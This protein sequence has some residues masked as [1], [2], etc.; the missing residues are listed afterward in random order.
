M[1]RR[2]RSDFPPPLEMTATPA[3]KFEAR[4]KR[5]IL[6]L[7]WLSTGKRMRVYQGDPAKLAGASPTLSDELLQLVSSRYG[8][9]SQNAVQLGGS[10]N[11]NVRLNEYVVRVY[12]PWVVAERLQ[13]MQRVRQELRAKGVPIPELKAARD[14]SYSCIFEDCL[15]EVEQFIDGTPMATWQQ[16]QAGFHA[17]GE[18]HSFMATLSVGVPSPVAN[19][20]PAELALAATE[21]VLFAIRQWNLTEEEERYAETIAELV[22]MLPNM[23]LPVQLVHGDFKD[24]N[25]VFHKEELRAVLDFDFMGVRP[26]IDDLALP[27]HTMLQHGIELSKVRKLLD[28]Y[29]SGCEIRLSNEERQALPYAMARMALSYLQY[30]MIPGDEAYRARCRR[31]FRTSRGPACEWWLRMLRN[32]NFRERGFV[33]KNSS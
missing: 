10:W 4:A 21:D 3:P 14:G 31:E 18:L 13:E 15:V 27:L 8:I 29:D 28:C 33:L 19:H 22:S 32:D 20:L 6:G 1:A 23:N 16:L 2:L 9:Q 30:L 7:Q 25:L 24:N 26:R 17:L 12:G 5:K 11:L